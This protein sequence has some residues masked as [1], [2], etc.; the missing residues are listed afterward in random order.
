MQVQ[1]ATQATKFPAGAFG[2]KPPAA[3]RMPAGTQIVLT[4]GEELF[5]EG[6]EAEFFYQVVSGAV[7]SYKLLSDGRRQID[8]FHL[9]H[10]IFGLEAGSE[11]RFSAEAVGDVTVIAYRRSRLGTLIQ[12]DPAFRD[13]L[14]T[15][16]LRSLE[17]AQDHMLLLGRK[18][19][20]E[21]MATFLL[22]MAQ[23]LSSD[24]EHFE[25]PMQRS[26][27]ADHLGLTIETV[28]R[29]LT[30]FARSGLIRLLPASRSIGLCN[31]MALRGLNA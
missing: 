6:D 27:I 14:M 23:R 2:L 11:H 28:S 13:R 19:A 8:A 20:Q 24:D 30:Q 26:D 15:A 12:D 17:R 7:R 10:D 16:T 1:T 29:T 25:L 22:D 21:K 4:K 5:A 9:P 3:A 31:K 18:T